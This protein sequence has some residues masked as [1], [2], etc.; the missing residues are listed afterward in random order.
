MNSISVT[1]NDSGQRLNRVL[2]K[3]VPSLYPSLMHK[4]L[5]T[6]R[7]KVNGKRAEAST[8]VFQ[9]DEIQL[10]IPDEFFSRSK[11]IPDFMRA[12]P[13]ITVLYEDDNLAV[14]YKPAGLL[15]HDDKLNFG[16]TLINRLLRYL[17]AKGEYDARKTEGFTPSLCNRLDRGTAG[18]VLAAKNSAALREL[19]VM[20]KE[21]LIDKYY[22]CVVISKPPKDGSYAAWIKKDTDRNIVSVH[23]KPVQGAKAIITDLSTLGHANGLWLV[24]AK[25]VTGRTHQIRAHLRHLGCPILGDGKYGDGNVNR[26]HNISRQALT[27]YKI[28]FNP[29]VGPAEFPVLSYLDGKTIAL[30][31]VWFAEQLFHRRPGSEK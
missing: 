18:I 28:V 30:E 21:R 31:T 29:S 11:T 8:R 25:L 1:P 22:L 4:Y 27:A 7:I 3:L 17:H 20:L 10:Y 19:N 23:D 15:V 26:R 13:K 2:E 14:I 24:E 16:D 6:K 9:G 5:R 12:S